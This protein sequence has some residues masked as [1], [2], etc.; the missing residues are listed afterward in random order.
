MYCKDPWIGLNSQ[1]HKDLCVQSWL[2]FHDCIKLHKLSIFLADAAKKQHF[3]IQQIV[4]K[5]QRV[6]VHQYMFCIGVLNDYMAY[7]PTVYDSSMAVEGTKK[8][9]VLFDE[10]DIV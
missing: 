3:Y 1:S 7:L 10:T 2:S 5:P 4:K 9:N 8:S 6:T